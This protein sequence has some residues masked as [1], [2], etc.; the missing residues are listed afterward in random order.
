[1]YEVLALDEAAIVALLRFHREQAPASNLRWTL[2]PDGAITYWLQDHLIIPGY[3]AHG[4]PRFISAVTTETLHQDNTAWMAKIVDVGALVRALLPEW[5]RRWLAA[6]IGWH[7]ALTI[8]VGDL[9]TVALGSTG[10]GIGLIDPETV[11]DV[12]VRVTAAQFVQMVLGYRP[13]GWIATQAGAVGVN[14][15]LGLLSALFPH[16]WPMIPASDSF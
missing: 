11:G 2:P 1:A 10:V 7:G 6:G 16:G 5:Q 4:D 14:G 12:A 15:A 3:D 8:A 9:G 13:V